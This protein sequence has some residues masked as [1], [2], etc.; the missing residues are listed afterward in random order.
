[1]AHSTTEDRSPRP[2]VLSF[3]ERP[4]VQKVLPWLAGAGMALGHAAVSAN[5]S[6]PQQGRC[7]SCGSCILVVG[8]LV[9]WAV[10]KKRQGDDFFVR[11]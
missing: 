1:M 6:V 11:R 4:A 7:V 10:L 8:S 2:A 5:C 9:G 3:A